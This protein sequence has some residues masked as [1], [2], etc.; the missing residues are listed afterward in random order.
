[1]V[2]VYRGDARKLGFYLPSESEMSV[3]FSRGPGENYLRN[4]GRGLLF[5]TNTGAVW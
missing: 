5:L 2:I 4:Y 3:I 1:M